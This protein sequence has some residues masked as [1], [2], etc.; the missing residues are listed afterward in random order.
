MISMASLYIGELVHVLYVMN[1]YM[2][3]YISTLTATAYIEV[4]PI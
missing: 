1:V 3:L 4:L 2:Y